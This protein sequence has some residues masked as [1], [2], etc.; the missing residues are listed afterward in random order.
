[1]KSESDEALGSGRST[2]ISADIVHVLHNCYRS[3]T[4]EVKL[5]CD[6]VMQVNYKNRQ[7]EKICT[8][9]SAATK[10]L[11][12]REAVFGFDGSGISEDDEAF[13][14]SKTYRV[15]VSSPDPISGSI[16]YSPRGE[17]GDLPSSSVISRALRFRS[18]ILSTAFLSCLVSLPYNRLDGFWLDMPGLSPSRAGGSDPSAS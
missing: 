3:F 10:S 7:I 12:G 16:A 17:K 9:A 15:L 6:V 13:S 1:M 14:F 5:D 8:N 11:L 2:A 4:A 18:S